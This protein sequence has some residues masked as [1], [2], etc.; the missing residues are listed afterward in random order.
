MH[1]SA[2]LD[3]N[4]L[5]A[6]YGE[7]GDPDFIRDEDCNSEEY[8]LDSE[9]REEEN[10][11][12]RTQRS[13]SLEMYR[14]QREG[15]EQSIYFS[16]Q[17]YD[18]RL[19]E[20]KNAHLRNM[21]ELERMYYINQR[22]ERHNEEERDGLQSRKNREA[23]LP[24]SLIPQVA[25]LA[26]RLQRINS[27]EELEFHETSSGS[28]QSAGQD[29][30]SGRDILL[31]PEEITTQKRFRFQP[32]TSCPKPQT[33]PF[34]QTGVRLKS[35]SMVTVPKPFQMM[36][37]EEERK[38]N[39][40]LTCSDVDLENTLLR[41]EL[42]SSE[43]R[44]ATEGQSDSSPDL[45]PEAFKSK[46]DSIGHDRACCPPQ[47]CLS[48]KPMKKQ[49]E[50]SIEMVKQREWPYINLLKATTCRIC[51]PQQPGTPHLCPQ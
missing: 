20:L 21:A 34:R 38:C 31:I 44:E 28:D 7:E 1:R 49:V 11:V 47:R 2:S 3:K 19:E 22:K 15:S 14:L 10:G 13:L 33:G 9:Y 17:E 42:K 51:L 12:G 6:L 36:L 39:N 23:R 8:D 27:Q 26:R 4:D 16:N 18:K 29:Q 5:M 30:T 48:A 24:V 25:T 46:S 32:K 37:R 35:T 41:R 45:E 50:L 43:N 40:V